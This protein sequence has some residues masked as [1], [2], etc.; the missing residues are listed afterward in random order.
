M[1][2][3]MSPFRRKSG[4]PMGLIHLNKSLDHSVSWELGDLEEGGGAEVS[5][6]LSCCLSDLLWEV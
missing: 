6:C 1:W 4:S 2:V 5:V 3:A